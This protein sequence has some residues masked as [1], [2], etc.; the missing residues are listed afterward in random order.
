[1]KQAKTSKW[2][3][4]ILP[5]QVLLVLSV[6]LLL[7]LFGTAFYELSRQ[8]REV[9]HLMHEEAT[10]L[11]ES[12]S[13]GAE[14]A[15]L[16]YNEIK[17]QLAQ[18]LMNNLRLLDQ[19][20]VR[21]PL[22]QPE[23][24]EISKQNQLY[25]INIFNKNGV[26]VASSHD[27]VHEGIEPL[28][29]PQDELQPILAG[30]ADS[31]VVGFKRSRFEQGMRFAVAIRRSRGGA[32]VANIAAEELVDLRRKIGVGQLIQHIGKDAT[33][34]AY[35]VW[36]DTSAIISATENITEL[37]SI[38]T[39]P[40]L[41]AALDN[42]QVSTRLIPFDEAQVFEAVRS[43]TFQN[44][45]VGLLRIG[46]W[47]DHLDVVLARIRQRF[48]I[49]TGL[50]VIGALIFLNLFIARRNE[51]AM[52]KAFLREQKFTGAILE[53]MADAVIAVD[54]AGRI[55]LLNDAAV[56]LFN[57]P[58]AALKG[59]AAAKYLP[60]CSDFLLRVLRKRDVAFQ[61]DEFP[62]EV[63]G[64]KLYLAA[65]SSLLYDENGQMNGAVI[66]LRD[67]TA[68]KALEKVVQRREKLSAMGKLASGV[69]HEIRNPLN[70]IGVLGQRLDLE[71]NPKEDE[72][73]Y[74][75]LVK[76]IVSEVR[77]VNEIIQRFL[78]F[79]RPPKLNA[80]AI[81][82][83]DFLQRSATIL[84]SEAA[85][86]SIQIEIKSAPDAH[87]NID[88]D[89]MT[90]VLLNLV[91]NAA[92]ASKPNGRIEFS[93][94]EQGAYVVLEIQDFGSGIAEDELSKIFDLYYTTKDDGTGMGLSIANQIVQAH[95]G[96]IEVESEIGQGS[97]FRI[98]L[99]F[100]NV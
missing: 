66:V 20:D 55:T 62:C 98:V 56:R 75:K 38:Q 17:D 6:I 72:P 92:D 99:P 25:R 69:A 91:R 61:D 50:L 89:Q 73:E 10:V 78:K 45:K 23:L 94:Y 71:F 41:V 67:L 96:V 31:L 54:T 64:K 33:G 47:A 22:T 82:L 68:R 87:I 97:I 44:T 95:G 12:L 51:T 65:K 11:I 27:E 86:K 29:D 93:S 40:F 3:M 15:I 24:N 52:T 35:I 58:S 4:L 32:I 19:L 43:F 18:R 84:Q 63:S 53:S 59:Q 46:L 21:Q 14:N 74:R 100:T 81:K 77:R 37:D 79:A 76:T 5:P 7:V 2:R 9:E 48:F 26:K 60:E 16:A 42:E 39:D 83:N 70:A 85:A 36:Q 57:L 49:L 88:T 90:Q 13:L 80:T 30:G 34:I 8:K 28:Y 1:M